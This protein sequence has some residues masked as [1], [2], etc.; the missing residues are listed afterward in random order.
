MDTHPSGTAA[1]TDADRR[2]EVD[3]LIA[4]MEGPAPVVLSPGHVMTD[5]A[6]RTIENALSDLATYLVEELEVDDLDEYLS[7][8]EPIR[9][10]GVSIEPPSTEVEYNWSV[11]VSGRVTVEVPMGVDRQSVEEALQEQVA[12]SIECDFSW[13]NVDGHSIDV[14]TGRVE[15]DDVEVEED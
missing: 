11:T 3:R 9:R 1:R 5:D 6:R 15:V 8:L 14:S 4:L 13:I 2:A 12:E 10:L 7:A